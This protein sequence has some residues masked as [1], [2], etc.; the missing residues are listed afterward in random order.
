MEL[1]AASGLL[2]L[3]TTP[4]VVLALT[5][6]ASRQV[7]P[8]VL[9]L[10][11]LAFD[12]VVTAFPVVYGVAQIPGSDWNWTG[13]LL[14]LAWALAFIA[15]GPLSRRDVGLTPRQRAGSVLPASLVTGALVALGVGV[16]LVFGEGGPFEA[17]ALLYQLSMPGLAEEL[18]Y[19]G[20]FLALLHRALPADE[21]TA[22]FW[23]PAVVTTLAFG[24]WHGLSL[25]GG[26]V[27]FDF[28]SFLYPLIGG[29]AF[30]WLRERTGSLLFPILAHNAANT[31]L[32]L[33]SMAQ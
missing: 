27:S 12:H 14:S 11:L 17:E 5:V 1:L 13:K 21:G 24:L 6:S 15:V 28:L 29:G 31:A 30:A 26:R 4:A 19:R 3:A 2:A 23:W 32:S 18:A 20:V 7:G 33:V 8:A 9:F 10:A 25:E 16:G 22:A